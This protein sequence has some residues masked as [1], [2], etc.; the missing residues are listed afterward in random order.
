VV[1][2]LPEKNIYLKG[3]KKYYPFENPKEKTKK[4][5]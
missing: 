2:L 1:L 4:T 3:S 5:K